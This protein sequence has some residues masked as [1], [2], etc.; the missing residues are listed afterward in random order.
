V[1]VKRPVGRQPAGRP[2]TAK[3][4]RLE[5][6]TP[7]ELVS[8]M[9]QQA[10]G[11]VDKLCDTMA[12]CLER[13][14]ERVRAALQ[15]VD[16]DHMSGS[17][18]VIDA[19]RSV[20][21]GLP[22]GVY[23]S[24]A[25]RSAPHQPAPAETDISLE[26]PPATEAEAGEAGNVKREQNDAKLDFVAAAMLAVHGESDAPAEEGAEEAPLEPV[27]DAVEDEAD[28][29]GEIV[30]G[31]EVRLEGVDGRLEAMEGVDG[32]LEAMEGVDGR[33]EAIGGVEDGLETMEGVEGRLDAMEGV[34]GRLD[35]ME[36]VEGR[37]DPM[38]GSES[39]A[40]ETTETNTAADVLDAFVGGL[41]DD[42]AFPAASEG[43]EAADAGPAAEFDS[44]QIQIRLPDGRDL[45]AAAPAAADAASMPMLAADESH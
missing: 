41:V 44:G 42:Y 39:V 3:R 38:A 27:L 21:T 29:G 17:T 26:E 24:T 15:T 12:A 34:E 20:L 32:R 45:V 43:E 22:E 18:C 35:A 40:V 4:P 19:D 23:V 33:L 5:Y 11:S 9:L 10:G 30:E 25:L 6:P 7:D 28:L 31:V 1:A 13:F 8:S 14:R 37:L 36:G 2:P 16:G